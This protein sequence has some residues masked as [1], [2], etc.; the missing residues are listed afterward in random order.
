MLFKSLVLGCGISLITLF[1]GSALAQPGLMEGGS[2][3][4]CSSIEMR[5]G[6]DIKDER[7]ILNFYRDADKINTILNSIKL[8]K[9]SGCSM[10]LPLSSGN[11]P[12]IDEKKNLIS[13]NDGFGVGRGGGNIILLHGE[14]EYIQDAKRLIALIDLPLNGIDLQLWGVQISSN[15]PQRLAETMAQVRARISETD[16]LLASTVASIQ[17]TSKFYL[18]QPDVIEPDFAEIVKSLG[19]ATELKGLDTKTLLD[20]YLT[21]VFAK[22]PEKFYETLYNETLVVGDLPE[23]KFILKDTR[24]QPY[25]DALKQTQHPPFEK[26]FRSRGFEPI[27]EINSLETIRKNGKDF[28]LCEKWKWNPVRLKGI[29]L[30]NLTANYERKVL[31]E[32]VHQYTDALNNPRRFDPDELGRTSDSLSAL[33]KNG[34][35]VLQKDIE[36]LFVQPTLSMLQEVVRKSKRVS[37]AQIGRNKISTLDGVPT[38]ISSSSISAFKTSESKN[39]DEILKTANDLEKSLGGIIPAGSSTALPT[40]KLIS[41]ITALSQ[42][43]VKPVEIKTGTN[44]TFTS[45]ISRDLSSSELNILLEVTDPTVTPTSQTSDA[46][47]IPNFSRIGQQKFNTT[48]YTQAL[49]FFDLSTFT[50]QATLDGGRF[51]I[52][53]IGQIWNAIFA[54][55]PRFGDLFSFPRGNQTRLHESLILT[56]SFITPTPWSIARLYPP[57][58]DRQVVQD[59]CLRRQLLNKYFDKSGVAGK[60]VLRYTKNVKDRLCPPD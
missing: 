40:S 39:L 50:S 16:Q 1:T 18:Q 52:P 48:V 43:T 30:V 15:N 10:I 59:F 36:D 27:C 49:D 32:F 31:L 2:T 29:S 11:N 17:G 42:E 54:P 3:N 34:N 33:L 22:D 58:V 8:S 53:V 24:L 37:F 20:I 23:G 9:K 25:Y 46:S 60:T 55:I 41:L 4:K 14:N 19:Y 5:D 28:R 26:F 47:K 35:D 7:I 21:G 56:T 6:I 51:R 13:A 57:T 12:N 38:K 45:G 44:I